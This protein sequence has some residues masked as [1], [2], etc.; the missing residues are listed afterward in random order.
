MDTTFLEQTELVEEVLEKENEHP[1]LQQLLLVVSFYNERADFESISRAYHFADLAHRGQ[2]RES[3]RPY[4]IHSIEVA[5]ILSNLH[6]D[7]TTIAAGLLHDIVEDTGIT[8]QQVGA[9]F[10]EEIATL[11]DG[12]TKIT[13]WD[14]HSVW[15]SAKVSESL[16]EEDSISQTQSSKS[17]TEKTQEIIQAE[18]LRK[19]LLSM[20]KD[21][22]VILIKFADRL[23]NMRT[24][25]SLNPDQQKR[26]ALETREVYAPL[27][28]RMGIS[29]VKSELED[30]S[31]KYLDSEAYESIREK[32]ALKKEEGDRYIEEI[33]VPVQKEL[34]ANGIEAEITG[35]PKSFYSIYG[36][37]KRRGLPFEEIYDLFAIRVIVQ[38]VRE[39][40]YVL[41]LVHSM[42]T[43]VTARFKDF[44]AT[45]KS[46]MY[47]SLHTTVIGPSG[48]M[49]EIQI[50]TNKMHQTAEEGIASHWRYK[51]G[52]TKEDELDK[53]MVWLRQLV[54]WQQDTESKDFMEELKI[55]LFQD[56]IFVFTPKG[57]L[58]RLPRGATPLDFA[59]SV[60][61]DV[62]IHSLGAKVNGK[63]SSLGTELKSG[64]TVQIIT[65]LKQEPHT[66]WLEIVKTSKARSS[67]KRW[68]KEK[69]YTH[70]VE[71][72]KKMLEREFKRLRIKV[73]EDELLDIAQ[74]CGEED[75]DHLFANV[76]NGQITT[77]RITSKI[78]SEPSHKGMK[79]SD[80]P[81]MTGKTLQ[82]PK[83]VSEELFDKKVKGKGIRIEGLD[84][85]MIQF[86][87]CCNPVPGDGIVGLIT[88]GRG[89]S[90][91]R[92]DC[93]NSLAML[94]AADDDPASER[95]VPA[96]WDT[97]KGQSFIVPILVQAVDRKNLLRDI[98]R[99]FAE[100]RT[101]IRS[102]SLGTKEDISYNNFELDV[103]NLQH[104]SGLIKKLSK[105]DDVIDVKRLDEPEALD[106]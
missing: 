95:I 105:I 96:E 60:H 104:L 106:S 90:I 4:I 27:A 2:F 5:R 48:E 101:N 93:P 69:R 21:I 7:S 33:K 1:E 64:D 79:R 89:V 88:R 61:T 81:G 26:I 100:T 23:N 80:I 103:R 85:M 77:G 92:V 72:G 45:P 25:E 63:M 68:L 75:I 67:I 24:L 36:K 50:R 86:A 31:L 83:K 14:A 58:K 70:S 44:I 55:D 46:N 53:H 35:R 52:L 73:K 41:G 40:Y 102:G 65:S 16:S 76:G 9:E 32:I 38:T 97:E 37:M 49:V 20:V 84:N 15:D 39:C 12:V 3:G 11:V 42:Y 51:E 43:P 10:G 18:N 19:M 78:M 62:G 47:R 30:L 82:G 74:S 94:H 56:E 57:A 6:L 29:R 22:R 71:L 34:M 17:P 66:N 98:T 54:E 13:E 91:H 99:V 8:H 28:H 59:F 87:K